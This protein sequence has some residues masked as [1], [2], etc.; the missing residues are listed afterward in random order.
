M[1]DTID[2]GLILEQQK[3]LLD[4]IAALRHV[5]RLMREDATQHR[6]ETSGLYTQFNLASGRFDLIEEHFNATDRRLDVLT[7]GPNC[8]FDENRCRSY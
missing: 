3:R 8:A 7:E 1:P 5:L 4:E 2:L 6:R